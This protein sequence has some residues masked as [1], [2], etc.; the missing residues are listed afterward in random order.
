MTT[1]KIPMLASLA[2]WFVA[3]SPCSGLSAKQV[4]AVYNTNVQASHGVGLY[5]VSARPGA[6][7]LGIDTF[8]THSVQEAQYLQKGAWLG[9]G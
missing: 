4:V 6:D 9:E 3:P 5:Y 1:S 7:I 8:T 2:L